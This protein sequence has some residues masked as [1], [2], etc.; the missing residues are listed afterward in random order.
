MMT[1]NLGSPSD[2]SSENLPVGSPPS[3]GAVGGGGVGRQRT[4]SGRRL[5]LHAER[6]SM[7]EQLR[8]VRRDVLSAARAQP[9]AELQ[10]AADRLADGETRLLQLD[11]SPAGAEVSAA[12]PEPAVDAQSMRRLQRDNERL[13]MQLSRSTSGLLDRGQVSILSCND[14]DV[15]LIVW[16][17]ERLHYRVYQEASFLFFVHA[18]CLEAL[19]LTPQQQTP[20]RLY[21]VAEVV[22]H[23]FCQARKEGNRYRVPRGTRF[24]RVRVKPWTRPSTSSSGGGGGSGGGGSGGAAVADLTASTRRLSLRSGE[25]VESHDTTS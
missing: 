6:D 16:D 1:S 13:R 15:V 3:E 17:A 19:G 7:L 18:D 24:Y 12:T 21:A 14:G 10:R 4:D 8:A 5:L 2:G 11:T 23:E 22:S 9:S 20:R 25:S